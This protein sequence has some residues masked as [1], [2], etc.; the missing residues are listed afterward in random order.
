MATPKFDRM[1]RARSVTGEN[2]LDDDQR[3]DIKTNIQFYKRFIHRVNMF[4]NI[5]LK[6]F[7]GSKRQHK[8]CFFCI[9]YITI[10]QIDSNKY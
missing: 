2:N 9:S 7:K 6:Q 4:M 10:K 5:D 8:Y 3:K 1:K